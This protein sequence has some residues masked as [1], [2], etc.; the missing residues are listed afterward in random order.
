MSSTRVLI[1]MVLAGL[2]SLPVLAEEPAPVVRGTSGL[3]AVPFQA[4]NAGAAEIRCSVAL[5]HWYSQDLGTAVVGKSVRGTLWSDPTDGNVFMLNDLEDRMPVQ[6][7]WC[8]VGDRAWMGRST[9]TLERK[10]G[11]VPAPIHVVCRPKSDG[12]ACE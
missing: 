11:V 2:F 12:L 5:A 9:I 10:A 3:V 8:G 7:L 4:D 1:G 6:T